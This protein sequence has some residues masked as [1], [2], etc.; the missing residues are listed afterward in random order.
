MPG[1]EQPAWIPENTVGCAFI[2]LIE[3]RGMR[4]GS[5]IVEGRGRATGRE[6]AQASLLYAA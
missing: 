3:G 4:E 5:R 6:Q 2:G 1:T